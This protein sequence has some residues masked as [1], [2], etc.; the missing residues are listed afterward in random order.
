MRLNSAEWDALLGRLTT[1]ELKYAMASADY[2]VEVEV[3]L[4]QMR[5]YI[6]MFG[7]RVAVPISECCRLPFLLIRRVSCVLV[8]C[9]GFAFV[10]ACPR[11]ASIQARDTSDVG[12]HL[13][14]FSQEDGALHSVLVEEKG[15]CESDYLNFM[16]HMFVLHRYR[17][18][19]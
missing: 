10:V 19:V 8:R 4:P 3:C 1:A 5:V 14:M 16:F 9:G 7:I 17:L 18:E 2:M 6:Y 15:K 12:V 13:T 11:C